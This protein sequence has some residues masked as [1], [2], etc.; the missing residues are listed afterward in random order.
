MATDNEELI[1]AYFY[2][3]EDWGWLLGGTT[4]KV[5]AETLY[6]DWLPSYL[7]DLEDGD[8]YAVKIMRKDM[9][10]AEIDALPDV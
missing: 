10:Q 2:Y 3:D 8:E 4:P 5:C 7:D 9:T 6:L 1:T